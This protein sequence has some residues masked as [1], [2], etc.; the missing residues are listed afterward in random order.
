MI[1]TIV[2]P[3]PETNSRVW[4]CHR[5]PGS[6]SKRGLCGDRLILGIFGPGEVFGEVPVFAGATHWPNSVIATQNSEVMFIPITKSASPA[7][8][9]VT[10][11]GC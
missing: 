5:R 9:S 2:L 6:G 10:R 4:R 7:A 11:I 3:W 1:K 8:A